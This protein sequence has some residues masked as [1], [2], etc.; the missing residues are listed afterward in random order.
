[1]ENQAA[2]SNYQ[3]YELLPIPAGNLTA[4][5]WIADQYFNQGAITDAETAQL[6]IWEAVLEND[7]S[8]P[9]SL[10]TGNLSTTSGYGSQADVVLASLAGVD[11]NQF[12]ASGFMWARSPI[13]QTNPAIPQDFIIQRIPETGTLLL[14]GFGFV[15]IAA[16][17]RRRIR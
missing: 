6:A 10:S 1:V 11:L 15:G 3:Q 9:L 16:L 12:D 17:N 2:D 4:A 14:L 13:G 7:S 8:I 5:A